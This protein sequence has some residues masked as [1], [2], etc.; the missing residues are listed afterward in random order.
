MATESELRA[1]PPSA[2]ATVMPHDSAREGVTPIPRHRPLLCVTTNSSAH[3]VVKSCTLLTANQSPPPPDWRYSSPRREA[4][5]AFFR[6]GY[7]THDDLRGDKGYPV[8]LFNDLPPV[9][10]AQAGARTKLM[11]LMDRVNPVE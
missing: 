8:S 5:G 3:A 10:A 7:M 2:G 6:A 4:P 9:V 11:R 1:F